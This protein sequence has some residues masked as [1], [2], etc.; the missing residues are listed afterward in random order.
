MSET[1]NAPIEGTVT[2]DDRADEKSKVKVSFESTLGREE[3]IKYF[4]AI[5]DGLKERTLTFKQGDRS[6]TL[7]P[8][9]RLRL[10][11]KAARRGREGKISF[12]IAWRD[13]DPSD[14]EITTS[15]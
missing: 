13:E 8:A 4:S 14:L 2:Q 6:L 10:G 7:T 9:E 5:L 11:V 1:R 12:E 3:A 15:P